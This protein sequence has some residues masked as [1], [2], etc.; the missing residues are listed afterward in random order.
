[1]VD[2]K[3]TVRQI[4]ADILEKVMEN[5][6]YA[7]ELLAKTFAACELN[8][9]DKNLLVEIVNGTLRWRG[10][11]EWLLE[12]CFNGRF[13]SA[14]TK[15]RSILFVSLYQ[16]RFLD[17]IPEY[18]AI[19]EGVELAKR[20]GGRP[21]GNLVNGVLRNYLRT[22]KS[23][24][25]PDRGKNPAEALAI[26]YS[27]PEWMV[28]RWLNRYGFEDTRLLCKY[29]NRRPVVTLRV[30]LMKVSKENLLKELE[31]AGVETEPSAHFDDF[32]RVRSPKSLTETRSFVK[33]HFSIQDEST[34]IA[35]LLLSPE[36]NDL[37]LDLCAAPGGKSCYI[38]QLM[39]DGGKVIAVDR[40][41]ARM[42]L[43][44]ENTRRL[45]LTSI[46]PI[47]A[48][49]T[50]LNTKTVD[51]VLLDAPCSGLG[52]LAKR[53]DLRWKRKL[54]DIT[55]I[56]KRQ[57]SLLGKTSQLLRAGGVLVYST[58]TIEPEEN[59]EIIEDF[60]DHHK[61]FEIDNRLKALSGFESTSKGY[62]ATLPHRDHVDGIFAV[63]LI[64]TE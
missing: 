43:L 29:N 47:I 7:D 56:R 42:K 34:A 50:M 57:I 15:L 51:R 3:P 30:N 27:H 39:R 10:Q 8:R 14:P 41:P 4:S 22:E 35:C 46:Q 20:A 58:C 63:R 31:D 11:L 19:N 28:R 52:V 60:L 36:E 64:K 55:S 24:I 21:W 40:S 2:R 53:A 17:K 44:Q 12:R 62:W 18:A 45:S 25:F 9:Q 49:S 38:A 13:D 32:V 16:L 5:R 59:E 26:R 6:V 23:L 1:M 61:N 54:S 33:G 37:V 48:D